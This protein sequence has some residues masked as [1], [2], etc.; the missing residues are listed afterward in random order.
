V[1]RRGP[2]IGCL[3][4]DGVDDYV[5]VPH[6]DSIM[7]SYTTIEAFVKSRNLHPEISP[8]L[9]TIISKE[10]YELFYQTVPE[11]W[12][13]HVVVGGVRHALVFPHAHSEVIN[14]WWH[15]AGSFDGKELRFYLNGELKASEAL[16]G[17]IDPSAVNLIIGGRYDLTRFWF[18]WIAHV[19]SY[20]RALTKREIKAHSRYLSQRFVMHPP[21]VL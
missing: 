10:T 18:D 17:T 1:W 12:E 3:F 13:F 4:L 21:L 14:K 19:R 5:E 16:T 9:R 11:Q 15:V 6:S 7:P 2:L 8:T 20:N